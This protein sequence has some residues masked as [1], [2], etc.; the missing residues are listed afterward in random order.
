MSSQDISTSILIPKEG[1][2]IARTG[3]V[4]MMKAE[5][6][7]QVD[8]VEF[9]FDEKLMGSLSG[10]GPEFILPFNLSLDISPGE[11]SILV[12]A[13]NKTKTAFSESRIIIFLD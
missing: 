4:V 6:A 13:Y 8:N 2:R 3:F 12:R 9:F 10:I 1:D 5:P 11:H 7:G